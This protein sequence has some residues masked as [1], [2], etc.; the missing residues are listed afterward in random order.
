MGSAE[1]RRHR[2]TTDQVLRMV[3]VGILAEGAGV[4]LI[5]G[6]L[7]EMG[8][9]GPAHRALTVRISQ[10]LEAA[11]GAGFHVQDHSPIAIGDDS[12]PEPDVAVVR[13]PLDFERLPTGADAVLV[14]EFSVTSQRADRRK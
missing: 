9:Q 6:E 4:E 11:Y 13:G 8:P 3:E 1:L 7:L 12:L 14:V 2:F 10:P 5:H